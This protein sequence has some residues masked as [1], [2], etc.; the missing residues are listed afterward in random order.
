MLDN[1]TREMKRIL[2]KRLPETVE[3]AWSRRIEGALEAN[4]QTAPHKFVTII[5][6]NEI[7]GTDYKAI[8]KKL[9]MFLKNDKFFSYSTYRILL[10]KDKVFSLIPPNRKELKAR[11]LNK[12]FDEIELDGTPSGEWDNFWEL[13]KPHK[14]AGQ[15]FFITTQ[16]KVE[17]L[18]QLNVIGIRN[19]MVLYPG[20]AETVVVQHFSR[21]P[22]IANIENTEQL[23]QES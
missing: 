6:D 17:S 7:N 22:C 13:F 11:Y 15:V 8:T 20:L 19:L 18:K 2:I 3:Y 14:K 10:W 23:I 9:Y 1:F 4:Q 12:H 5:I 16:E 21:I